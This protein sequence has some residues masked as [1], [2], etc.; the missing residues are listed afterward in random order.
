LAARYLY[1]W[2]GDVRRAQPTQ[3]GWTLSLDANGLG[4]RIRHSTTTPS[5]SS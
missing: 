2:I 5:A 4:L 3:R 1:A